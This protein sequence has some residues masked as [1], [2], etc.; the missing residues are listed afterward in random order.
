MIERQTGFRQLYVD[1]FYDFI[2]RSRLYEQSD[3]Q[4]IR[5]FLQL[6]KINDL[7]PRFLKLEES[8]DDSHKFL[9]PGPWS[10]TTQSCLFFPDSIWIY[11]LTFSR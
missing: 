10:F 3:G 4:L 11:S 7:K 2:N 5:L 8:I 9:S 6:Y 1:P